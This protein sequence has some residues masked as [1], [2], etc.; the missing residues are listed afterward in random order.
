MTGRETVADGRIGSGGLLQLPV[1]KAKPSIQSGFLPLAG[2]AL[3]DVEPPRC[4]P[5]SDGGTEGRGRT[6]NA[7]PVGRTSALVIEKWVELRFFAPPVGRSPWAGPRAPRLL[8][9]GLGSAGTAASDGHDTIDAEGVFGLDL[10]TLDWQRV[11]RSRRA[12]RQG[13]RARGR[14]GECPASGSHF[15]PGHRKMGRTS[16]LRPTSGAFTLRLIPCAALSPRRFEP[17]VKAPSD[18]HE[19]LDGEGVFGT[20]FVTVERV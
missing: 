18:D 7:P 20:D 2:L 8:S 3:S 4:R 16:I 14:N 12:S 5:A 13:R 17:V 9:L 19:S 10:V 15:G 11:Q 6:V 1:M